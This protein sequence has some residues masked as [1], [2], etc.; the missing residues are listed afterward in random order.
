VSGPFAVRER[1]ALRIFGGTG[2][3]RFEVLDRLAERRVRA[4]RLQL[5]RELHDGLAQELALIAL[6][7]DPGAATHPPGALEAATARALGECRQMIEML[8]GNGCP[9]SGASFAD[10]LAT[11]AARVGVAIETRV[12]AELEIEPQAQF[13]LLRIVTESVRNA[14]HHGGATRIEVEVVESAG[15][16]VLRVADNGSGFDP[17]LIPGRRYGLVGMRERAERLGGALTVSAGDGGT[18]VELALGR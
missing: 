17:E 7:A 14:V 2:F 15:E 8:R 4:E 11:L 13:E 18:Q 16:L 3:R 9:D 1:I 12:D 5:A 10:A 6:L